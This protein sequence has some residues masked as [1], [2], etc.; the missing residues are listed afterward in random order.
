MFQANALTSEMANLRKFAVKLTKNQVDAD[1]L[2]QA[3]VLRALEKKEL[4]E[5]GTNLFGWSS[6]IMYNLFVTE[7]R[8]KIKFETQYDPD[9][10]INAASVGAQQESKMAYA[11]V[12][13]AMEYLSEDHKRIL[14]M[15]CVRNMSYTE[16]SEAL[17]I[18]VGTVRSRLSRA[19]ESLQCALGVPRIFVGSANI[20]PPQTALSASPV[21]YAA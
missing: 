13:D 7:Y 11:E 5:D 4:F 18:P 10:Y 20:H 3:T 1:D 16:V 15:V 6:K 17:Q 21:R 2:V 9:N 14:I 19:R 12:Q 8:R